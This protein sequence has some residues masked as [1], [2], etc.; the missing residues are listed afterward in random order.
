M[1]KSLKKQTAQPTSVV[2]TT[3]KEVADEFVSELNEILSE[4]TL[5]N[6]DIIVEVC[7]LVDEWR[8]YVKANEIDYPEV[9]G[10]I[11][12]PLVIE[13][14]EETPVHDARLL[15]RA[16]REY[17]EEQ[18]ITEDEYAEMDSYDKIDHRAGITKLYN[19]LLKETT[20]DKAVERF[21]KGPFG[22]IN[23]A[24]NKVDDSA[25][26]AWF[27]EKYDERAEELSVL[28]KEIEE[29]EKQ[30]NLET[31]NSMTKARNS[32]RIKEL[33]LAKKSIVAQLN[34]YKSKL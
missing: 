34:H 31:A 27:Q 1:S 18:D 25:E 30:S 5:N 12:K 24:E 28:E 19:H 23:V 14:G 11:S 7:S 3:P 26:K 9:E 13:G 15:H 33:G 2:P 10:V 32:A 16:L 29:I 22:D 6:E 17:L 21:R 4:Q 8:E 20:R